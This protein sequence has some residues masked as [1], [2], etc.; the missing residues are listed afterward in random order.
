MGLFGPRRPCPHCGKK[1]KEPSDPSGFLCPRCAKPGPWARSEQVADWERSEAERERLERLQA[2]ALQRYSEMLEALASGAPTDA[3]QLPALATQTGLAPDQ[4]AQKRTDAFTSYVQRAV[5]DEILTPEEEDHVQELVRIL[6]VDL[7]AFLQQ[8]PELGRHVM[9]AEANG[10]F[11][12]EVP[13]SRLVQKKGEIVH[14]EVQATLL[15]DVTVRQSQGGYSGFSFPIGKTGIRYRVGGY[16]GH[17]VEVG[18]KRVPADDGFLV[19]S[20]QRAVFM[21][22]KKTIELP[23][24]K[25]VNLTV[26]SDGVQFHVS[27]RQTAPMFVA[28]ASDVVAAFVHAAAQRLSADA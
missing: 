7:G 12:P 6:G 25:L 18:T 8:D 15:K 3:T 13:S 9:V 24:A 21:G 16:R 17:S 26:F 14:L 4:L 19:I 20:S 5:G 28:P 11:L 22:N 10:G 27:N 2:D 23:Y 1:V